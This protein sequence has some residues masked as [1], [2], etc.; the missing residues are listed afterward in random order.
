MNL[1]R[2]K[3]RNISLAGLFVSILFSILIIAPSAASAHSEFVSSSPTNAE[4]LAESPKTLEVNFS[5]KITLSFDSFQLV[6]DKSKKIKTGKPEVING[7]LTM[8]VPVSKLKDGSYIAVYTIVSTDTHVIKGAFS[9]SIGEGSVSQ[10]ENQLQIADLLEAK[11]TSTLL[12]Q[13]TLA[14]QFIFFLSLAII[15]AAVAFKVL[16]TESF[17][18][19]QN[20]IFYA[21]NILL[22]LSTFINVGLQAATAGN[23]SIVKAFTP[24]VLSEEFDSHFGRIYLLRIAIS[25]LLIIFWKFS[26]NSI[27][28][29]LLILGAWVLA[30][31]PALT[32]HASSGDYQ[33]FAFILDVTH[34]AG[35]SIWFGGLILL[36]FFLKNE[37]YKA[38]VK[39]FSSIAMGCVVVIFASGIF[40]FWRQSQSID[41][42]TETFFGK[43]VLFKIL[44]F[45]AVVAI[46]YFS[47]R[48][49][50]KL[51]AKDEQESETRKKLTKLVY[52][53]SV[54]L[55]VV[56]ILSSVVVNSV[57]AKTA[58]EAGVEKQISSS[59]YIVEVTV[60][61]TKI[62]P[63]VIHV[64]VLGKNGVPK[65]LG[66]GINT[67]QE[68]LITLT[69]SNPEKK[70]DA[71]PV[72]M[73]FLG[74]NHF[75][76][77]DS[78]ISFPGTW[79]LKANIKIDEFNSETVS[80][81]IK[82]R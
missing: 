57:P 75:V 64:Y 27:S 15:I 67:L 7:G 60:D 26:N 23:F 2:T 56:M 45:F 70:I 63:N 34:V 66:V 19:K 22:I 18:K 81:K 54:I 58:L 77:T 53:E 50:N 42:A 41:A 38:I 46:A 78:N 51:L 33:R 72:Q 69:W 39:Q 52:L 12:R 25:F 8:S 16:I 80:T 11:K 3:L 40:A 28:K 31:T 74:L 44:F 68:S 1:M 79:T 6:D 43:L 32:G 30:L 14:A 24:S 35:A 71:L 61:K 5:D 36:P 48:H 65:Q 21:S 17:S 62:G 76:S 4:V 10:N 55:V 82:F 20:I 47:R 49:V 29:S 59:K 73:R 37:N 13:S 9:F